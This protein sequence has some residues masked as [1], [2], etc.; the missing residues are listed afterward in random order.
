MKTIRIIVLILILFSSCN[1]DQTE[2]R[3]LGD[4]TISFLINDNLWQNSDEFN[5]EGSINGTVNK[6][7]YVIY[8]NSADAY[9]IVGKIWGNSVIYLSLVNRNS[10]NTFLLGDGHGLFSSLLDPFYQSTISLSFNDKVYTSKE[11]E[12]FISL[13]KDE[14]DSVNEIKY[15]EGTFEATLYNVDDPFDIIEI[16]DGKFNN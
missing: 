9:S 11:N 8:T 12:G 5:N 3:R 1:K 7:M 13:S 2:E 10:N 14:Y 15:F 16:T 4:S 6:S